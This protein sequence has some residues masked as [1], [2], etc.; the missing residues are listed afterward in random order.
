MKN[1][2]TKSRELALQALF[3]MDTRHAV[4]AEVLDAYCENFILSH[5]EEDQMLFFGKK[6]ADLS[7]ELVV[8]FFKKIVSGI[9]P[10]ISEIDAIIE[11]FSSNWKISRMGCVDRNAIRIAVYEFLYCDDI[12]PKVSIN[13]AINMGKKF[14]TGESGAFINGILD[15]IRIALE[16]DK[17]RVPSRKVRN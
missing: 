9:I 11:R 13:E 8:P 15:S 4:S 10:V 6:G 3:Y 14:G 1:P 12:P 16:K 5:E 17:I 7:I 2:R